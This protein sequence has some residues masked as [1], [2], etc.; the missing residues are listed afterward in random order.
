MAGAA[1]GGERVQLLP[2]SASAAASTGAPLLAGRAAPAP[3]CA[4]APPGDEVVDVATGNGSPLPLTE[5]ELDAA[6]GKLALASSASRALL[7]SAPCFD[8]FPGSWLPS[9][10][11]SRAFL[12]ASFSGSAPASVS[13][14]PSVPARFS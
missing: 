3:L 14:S 7:P 4:A 12:S 10:A 1:N 5:L 13:R 8:S 2:S 9:P 6:S 11:G